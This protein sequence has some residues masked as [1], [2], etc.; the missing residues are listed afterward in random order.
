MIP[1]RRRPPGRRR[2][3]FTLLEILIVMLIL[4]VLAAYFVVS[5][6][7]IFRSSKTK[8]AEL[9]LQ[10]LTSLIEQFRQIEGD[11]PN[12]AL[13]AGASGNNDNAHAESLFLALYDAD[14]TGQR[15]SQEWLVNT[16]GDS[17]TKAMTI[18]PGREL[19]EFGDIW[20]NPILYFDHRHFEVEATVWAAAPEEELM[21]QRATAR[22]Q[23]TT[24]L[25]MNNQTFQLLSAG[26][27][28]LFGT[29]DD[30]GNFRDG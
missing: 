18:L 21:Q 1:L 30:L 16:D 26:E 29:E 2:A 7:R 6:G 9:R 5:G 20:G 4:G 11:Y 13:P 24:G 25:W 3:G 12:D 27:D 28:G 15:P 10:E 8:Q 19:M 22:K 17:T 23:S 14:Y